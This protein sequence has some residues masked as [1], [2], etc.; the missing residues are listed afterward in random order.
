MHVQTTRHS[1]PEEAQVCLSETVV[2]I[3]DSIINCAGG[4]I[5][6]LFHHWLGGG[7]RQGST[8]T[9]GEQGWAGITH[10]E[11]APDSAPPPRARVPV[12]HA[13]SASQPWGCRHKPAGWKPESLTFP[14]APSSTP[15]RPM[16]SFKLTA[17]VDCFPPSNF[18]SLGRTSPRKN[19]LVCTQKSHDDVCYTR[20]HSHTDK[21]DQAV[22]GQQHV[23]LSC[24]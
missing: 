12:C 15:S 2:S 6:V 24:L 14:S 20:H 22:P 18:K 16:I 8:C 4:E 5:H 19:A 13:A 23:P 17:P 7:G 21:N 9:L 10:Q 3:M 1:I 11:G